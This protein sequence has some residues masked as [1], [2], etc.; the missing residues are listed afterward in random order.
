MTRTL[1][2]LGRASQGGHTG[3]GPTG[4]GPP[5]CHH[6][7]PRLLQPPRRD[8][9]DPAGRGSAVPPGAQEALAQLPR[10]RGQYGG[11]LF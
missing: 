11:R 2:S 9:L 5:G 7:L 8:G 1:V 10:R 4:A 6:P 3:A